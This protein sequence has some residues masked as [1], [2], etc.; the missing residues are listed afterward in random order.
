MICSTHYRHAVSPLEWWRER[1]RVPRL[2][3][4]GQLP[5]GYAL[6]VVVLTGVR[7]SGGQYGWQLASA[8]PFTRPVRVQG[9]PGIF[10]LPDHLLA[11]VLH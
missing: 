8:R 3:P 6:G 11:G 2:P 7:R 1:Q 10:E 4:A 5:Y 9:L